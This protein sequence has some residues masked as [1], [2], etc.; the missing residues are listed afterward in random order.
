MSIVYVEFKK[1]Y[2]VLNL[3]Y[4]EWQTTTNFFWISHIKNCVEVFYA[5]LC[6]NS[7][8]SELRELDDV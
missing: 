2:E 1:F 7:G 6:G 4:F 5:V 8:I 3:T